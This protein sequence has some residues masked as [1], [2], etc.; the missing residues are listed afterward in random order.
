ML[1]L[2]RRINVIQSK[3]PWLAVTLVLALAGCAGAVDPSLKQLP[4]RVELKDVPFFRGNIY[5]SGPGALASMLAQHG[6]QITP[7]LLDKPLKLPEGEGD[8]AQSMPRLAREYGYV[9][10]PLAPSLLDLLQQV[11]AGF[12]VMV[13]FEDGSAWWKEQ[14]YGVLVGFNRLKGTVLLQAGMSR[15]TTM[16]FDEFASVWKSAGSWALLVQSPRRLPVPVDRQRWLKAVDD[17]AQAG[18]EQAAAEAA[19]TLER[20]R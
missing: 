9:V 17:L 7:G 5:H 2:F 6:V 3:R 10:Y 20:A 15:R 13:R 11:S 4:D 1:A 16:S 12:P 14:R 8:L 19:K 18:Q